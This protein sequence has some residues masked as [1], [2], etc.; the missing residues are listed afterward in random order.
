MP[1]LSRRFLATLSLLIGGA[2]A[3]PAAIRSHQ[4]ACAERV[5]DK[6][7]RRW[8]RRPTSTTN[9]GFFGDVLSGKR[10][11]MTF[12]TDSEGRRSS[13]TLPS[14][15]QSRPIRPRSPFVR[16][17]RA[18]TPRGIPHVPRPCRR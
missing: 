1:P 18:S 12:S 7:P 4:P 17:L 6:V 9:L 3:L 5:V 14:R 11:W 13:P 8:M 2:A 10:S 16:P 15:L